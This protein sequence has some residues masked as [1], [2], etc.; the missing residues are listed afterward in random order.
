VGLPNIQFL[1]TCKRIYEEASLIP[2]ASNTFVFIAPASFEA[3]VSKVLSPEQSHALRSIAIWAPI[4][5]W[6]VIDKEVSWK[7]WSIPP[8]IQS[9]DLL[10][11]L[12]RLILNFSIY[13][14]ASLEHVDEIGGI[15]AFSR[16]TGTG[17]R[18]VEI[19]MTCDEGARRS[20]E[21]DI[22][23]GSIVRYVKNITDLMLERK[24]IE[25][26]MMEA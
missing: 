14:E 11:G 3:F 8:C 26:I 23:A 25:A 15:L 2:Y 10:A 13:D 18:K 5:P 4:A 17:L 24:S 12:Q 19:T 1:R 9:S 22:D 20:G 21:A 16:T 6:N 7:H